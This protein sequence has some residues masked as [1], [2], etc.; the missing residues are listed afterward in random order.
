MANPYCQI[1]GSRVDKPVYEQINDGDQSV[2][3][4]AM[5]AIKTFAAGGVGGAKVAPYCEF[6]NKVIASEVKRE[7]LAIKSREL[8]L[9]YKPKSDTKLGSD[10]GVSEG[11]SDRNPSGVDAFEA[12][13]ISPD[14]VDDTG[15]ESTASE[16]TSGTP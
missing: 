7:E 13:G 9:K 5:A 2:V 1:N 6:L 14:V 16:G 4:L 12:L 10:N 11:E 8:E 15:A 3:A